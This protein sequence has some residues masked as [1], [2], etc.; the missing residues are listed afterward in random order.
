MVDMAK[1]IHKKGADLLE[2]GEK[3]LAAATITPV[4]QFKK[5]VA[6]GAVGGLA[7]AAIGN[8]IKGKAEEAE[9]GTMADSFPGAKQAILAL[10][11]QRWIVFE[12]GAMSGGPKS[13]SATW[14]HDQIRGIDIEKGKLTSKVN[15]A[16]ADGSVAQ[17]EAVKAAKPD[18][19]A[20]AAGRLR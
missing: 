14:P 7:G 17:V 15:L 2:P 12:Q 11:N 1:K 20:E 13:I 18:K 16:F 19:L 10:S 6:F 8:A 5:T 4:G 3:I 9:A